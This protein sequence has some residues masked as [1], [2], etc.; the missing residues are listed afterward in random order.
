[1][2]KHSE[3][4]MFFYVNDLDL[5]SKI[6]RLTQ[7]NPHFQNR[8]QC[9]ERLIQLGIREY[10]RLLKQADSRKGD[11]HADQEEGRA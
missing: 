3:R 4:K 10:E 11:D 1:M 5:K 9:I 2:S 7:Q 6:E 8:S